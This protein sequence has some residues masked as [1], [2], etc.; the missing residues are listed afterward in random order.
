MHVK[1]ARIKICPLID[2]TWTVLQ[3]AKDPVR[4]ASRILGQFR[5]ILHAEI[6]F[7]TR[8]TPTVYPLYLPQQANERR[9]AGERKTDS[10]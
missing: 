5:R 9:V 10:G 6:R 4:H 2:S 8:A 3:E 1:S 7:I